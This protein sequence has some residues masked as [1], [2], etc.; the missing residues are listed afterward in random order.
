M[1][2]E[3]K[4]E[5]TIKLV[6]EHLEFHN[7]DHKEFNTPFDCFL[8][9]ELKLCEETYDS[10]FGED[11]MKKINE[12]VKGHMETEEVDLV[13]VVYYN[14]VQEY[15]RIFDSPTI[16]VCTISNAISVELKEMDC[17]N[18]T[19]VYGK[20]VYYCEVLNDEDGEIYVQIGELKCYMNEFVRVQ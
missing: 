16:A 10:M 14:K 19:L 2:F 18:A 8:D 11:T 13:S 15:A 6:K 7:I 1:I 5:Y 9:S 17:G 3:I 12:E 20:D 4:D